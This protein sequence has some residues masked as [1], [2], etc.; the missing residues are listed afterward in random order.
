MGRVRERLDVFPLNEQPRI[1]AREENLLL[2]MPAPRPGPRFPEQPSLEVVHIDQT[3]APTEF[4]LP[5]SIYE[6]EVGRIEWQQMDFRQ[7]MYH[8]NLD[9]DELSYQI[10]GERTLLT[11]MG[12][13]ELTPGD[14][15]GIPVG[16]CHDNWGRK[17]SHLLFYVDA[18]SQA[19]LPAVR[20]SDARIPPF[21]GWAPSTVNEAIS[22]HKAEVTADAASVVAQQSDELLILQRAFHHPERLLVMR[23]DESFAGRAWVWKTRGLWIGIAHCAPTDGTDYVRHRNCD[24]VQ[25]QISGRRTLVS[26]RGMVDIEPGDFVCIPAG[27]AFTSLSSHETHYLV[28]NSTEALQRVQDAT[29]LARP[30][31]IAALERLR[32]QQHH[33]VP[34]VHELADTASSAARP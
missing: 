29:K 12:T 1:V 20:Y 18:P 23:A 14:F 13:V 4:A 34:G 16:V 33:S 11:E 22:M 32:T 24:E 8:R 19:C 28:V 15:C 30:I 6:C 27:V 3:Y 2:S 10:S 26:Q 5:R 17:E 9:V 7:P 31:E 25:Y 21:E